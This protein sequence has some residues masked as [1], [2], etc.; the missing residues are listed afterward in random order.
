MSNE[1]ESR[2]L[3]FKNICNF[4]RDLN[5]SFGNRQKSLLLYAHLVEKTGIMHEEPIKKHI[6]IFYNFIKE[7][8]AGIL[9]KDAHKFTNFSIS[10]SDKVGIDFKEIL[11]IADQDEKNAIFKHLLALL[12]VLDPSSSARELLKKE[13]ES[14]QK[15]GESGNE[16]NFLK[17]IIDKVSSQIDPDVD[18]P[19]QLMNKM[20]T[21][22]VITDIVD[23]MNTSF[24]DGNLDMNKMMN[25]MQMLMGNISSMVQSRD[26]NSSMPNKALK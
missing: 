7:N 24:N 1:T 11:Q 10:Y 22:G 20:M 26:D 5:E 17:N 8:E 19:M 21:S 14:K 15:K 3:V 4:I 18:N 9:A 12:A 2:V 13:I 23:D 25:T 16:E 6:S